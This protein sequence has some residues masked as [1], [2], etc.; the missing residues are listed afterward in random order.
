MRYAWMVGFILALGLV[1]CAAAPEQAISLKPSTQYQ[2]ITAENITRLE[3][4]YAVP[5]FCNFTR[6]SPDGRWLESDGFYAQN[7]HVYDVVTGRE[8]FKAEKRLVYSPDAK[9][10]AVEHD[11][12]YSYPAFVKQFELPDADVVFSPDSQ[13]LFVGEHGLYQISDGTLVLPSRGPSAEFSAQTTYMAIHGVGIY[14]VA[15]QQLLF[16]QPLTDEKE[17][18]FYPRGIFSP[19]EKWVVIL[20]DGIYSLPAWKK[21][22]SFSPTKYEYM[23]GFEFSPDSRYFVLEENGVY[24]VATWTLG[25]N[26]YSAGADFTK[27]GKHVVISDGLYDLATGEKKFSIAAFSIHLS[28]EE[29]FIGSDEQ[30]WNIKTGDSANLPG[31]M[32]SLFYAEDTL[33]ITSMAIYNTQT[34]EIIPA[35]TIYGGPETFNSSSTLM[36]TVHLDFARRA[37]RRPH[38]GSSCLLYGVEGN[39]WPY[40]SGIVKT[41]A[42]IDIY[43]SPTE[44]VNHGGGEMIV[45]SQTVDHAW[46]KVLIDETE[47]HF[48]WI[49]AADVTPISMPAGIPIE[50]FK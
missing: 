33:L 38:T 18:A 6:F 12:L 30:L 39:I 40:R 16:A 8:L 48:G 20:K 19:D 36:S 45:Y 10:I 23:R 13:Y 35:N 2:V 34:R 15:R 22:F 7:N 32:Y 46:Y 4:G 47:T 42:D 49:R 26:T 41:D 24:D 43:Q 28:P 44:V 50:V 21:A 14:N 3:L 31:S 27:D 37:A 17:M 9:W 5:G 11:A 25:I 29:Q 1:G